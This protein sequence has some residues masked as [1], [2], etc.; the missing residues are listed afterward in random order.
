[1][2]NIQSISEIDFFKIKL[3][4]KNYLSATTEFTDHDFEAS[5]LDSLLDA[6]AYEAH[7][8]GA[9]TNMAFSETFLDS[10]TQ[11]I[12]IVSRANE[13][14]YVPRSIS[15]PYANIT[16]SFSVSGNPQQYI[17]P[18]G[19]QFVSTNGNTSYSFVT[20]TDI[21][22]ENN[23]SNSYSKNILIYQGQ[24]ATR[25]FTV[26][27]NNT[28]QKFELGSVNA[29]TNFLTVRWKENSS[30][31]T[32]TKFNYVKDI[33]ISELDSDSN[34][35]FLKENYTGAFEV[36]FGD[37]VIGKQM[38][39]GN[40]IEL[41]YLITDGKSANNAK[42]FTMTTTPSGL[43]DISIVTVD[44]ATG[45]SDK[46]TKESI[47]YLAPFYYASQE[48]AVT[49]KDYISLVKS[50]YS[51]VDDVK[52]WGG[53]KNSPPF[54]GKVF[55]AI[56]P[57]DGTFLSDTT[58]TIIQNDI[59]SK[60][61]IVSIRPEIVDPE[62]TDVGVDT[63]I[64]YDN[65]LY[66]TTVSDSLEQDVIATITDFFDA[67][68]N[69][70]GTPLYFSKLVK[71]IDNTSDAILSS[72]TNLTLTKSSEI[73]SGSSATYT[74][75]FNNSITEGAVRSNEFT[76]GGVT[77]KIIDIPSNTD[78]T[79]KLAVCR[80]TDQ[81]QTIYLTQDTGTV[82]YNTGEI[83]IENFL[84][85]T[86]VGDSI[87]NLLK[88]TVSPG[89]FID[90]SNPENVFTDYNVYTNS[91]DQIIRLDENDITVTLLSDGG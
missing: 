20:T 24:Y 11:R 45:G 42:S 49:E 23:G 51:N 26:N 15:S 67:E 44:S 6:L 73:R 48:R 53:E 35:Y 22:F 16:L 70:F 86:I 25:T 8:I 37:G 34:V 32:W 83:V 9:Y 63:V 87:F 71:A 91:R 58:K 55:I 10:A 90:T 78:A 2:T 19:T 36:Y 1:M 27:T 89:S 52:V 65:T 18:K 39:N 77:W 84:I 33:L 60:Y 74:F 30:S 50:N 43:S 61:N 88:I 75:E 47:K 72:S 56:K 12:S 38:V 40:I 80:N 4:L 41:S 81:G 29:D 66:S 21:T 54:Y 7:Y 13:L 79:G 28:L 68:T 57:S 82:N 62:Y 59:I 3:A 5:G 69:K 17:L 31:T 76:I 64:I 14:G 46:E 85:D